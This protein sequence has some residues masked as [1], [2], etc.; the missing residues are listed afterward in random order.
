MKRDA[1]RVAY[2][3]YKKHLSNLKRIQRNM[4]RLEL[5]RSGQTP[6]EGVKPLPFKQWLKLVHKPSAYDSTPEE[7]QEHI[8]EIGDWDE[9]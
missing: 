1:A 8:E 7:I 4:T 9:D 6:L 5:K 2:K 3:R